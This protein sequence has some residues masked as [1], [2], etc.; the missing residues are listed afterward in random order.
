MEEHTCV[1]IDKAA[2]PLL[3][4]TSCASGARSLTWLGKLYIFPRKKEMK[5]LLGKK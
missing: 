5:V 4:R 3:Y 2:D 1:R